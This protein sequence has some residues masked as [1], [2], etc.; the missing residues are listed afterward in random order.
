MPKNKGK[1]NDKRYNALSNLHYL[2]GELRKYNTLGACIPFIG[3]PA[4][5]LLAVVTIFIPKIVLDAVEKELSPVDFA[6]NILTATLIAAVAAVIS[7]ILQNLVSKNSSGFGLTHLTKLWIEK[8]IDM[9]YSGFSSP[10]GKIKAEKAHHSLDG[11]TRWGIGSYF[12]RFVAILENIFS[13]LSY[14]VIIA[15]LNPLIIIFLIMTYAFSAAF[16]LYVEKWKQ[17][18]KD[19]RA[20]IDHRLNY[21]AHRTRNLSIGKDI[22]IYTMAGWLREMAAKAKEDKRTWERK[23]AEKEFLQMLLGGFIVFLRDGAAYAYLIY[24]LLNTNMSIGDFSLYFAAI[25]GFGVWLSNMIEGFRNLTEA[26]NFVSDFREFMDFSDRMNKGKGMPLPDLSKPVSIEL[27]DLSFAYEGCDKVIFDTINLKIEAGEKLAIVG[28]NGAGKTTLV[29]L[30]C[31]LL[32]PLTGRILVDGTDISKFN[33]DEYYT[34]F[35]AVFQDSNVLP[36]SIADNIALN[37]GGVKD[38][39]RIR[40]C[41]ELAGL[42]E[43]IDSLP[44]GLATNLV[45]HISENGTELSG[46][47][48]QRLLLARALYKNAPVIILDEPTA[49]LDPIAENEIY[50]KYDG[51][52]QGRTSIYISHRLSSTR[53]CDRIIF[54]DGGKIVECG[55]HDALMASGGKYADMFEIQSRY[56]RENGGEALCL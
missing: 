40:N 33:R 8:A 15:I 32:P 22:R 28:T 26:N 50:L 44:D 25:S 51:L 4:K 13:F 29:K 45:K 53:F 6:I 18:T 52:T 9:D 56:Y 54:I 1:I 43:K 47:E 37:I 11:G 21:I 14:S 34:L 5:V 31:G 30:I 35:S 2:F 10:A 19:E 39:A 27:Q 23:I 41:I 48:L 12:P 38:D 17:G 55:T 7:H 3:F 20:V 49:A 16:A 24:R 36:V 46:G 42:T